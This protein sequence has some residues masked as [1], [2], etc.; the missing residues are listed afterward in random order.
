MTG[1]EGAA[2][3]P[4][5]LLKSGL[6]VDPTL[7]PAL[8]DYLDHRLPGTG[9]SLPSLSDR[10]AFEKS[11]WLPESRQAAPQA[12][13]IR[14]FAYLD[15]IGFPKPSVAATVSVSVL[16]E[17]NACYESTTN[18]IVIDHRLAGDIWVAI[19]RSIDNGSVLGAAG[20]G[21]SGNF[22]NHVDHRVASI[23]GKKV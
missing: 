15:R 8:R 12:E 4:D 14:Y 19:D 9:P 10:V 7:A 1:C 22:L 17:P 13:L 20:P 2:T 3:N 5:F 6:I 18:R 23:C 11:E 16:K 21:K